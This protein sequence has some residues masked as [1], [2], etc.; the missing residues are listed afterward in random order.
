LGFG[1]WFLG[2]DGFWTYLGFGFLVH[3]GFGLIWVLVVSNL[4]LRFLVHLVLFSNEK[5]RPMFI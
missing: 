4:G 2:F 1:F 5:L 3:L